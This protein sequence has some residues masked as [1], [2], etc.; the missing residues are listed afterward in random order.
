[1]ST[2]LVAEAVESEVL[3]AGQR[4]LPELAEEANLEYRR[5]VDAGQTMLEAAVHAGRALLAIRDRI[6]DGDWLEWVAEH[7]DGS[8]TTAR[9]CMR[10]AHHAQTLEQEAVTGVFEADVRLQGLSYPFSR[11]DRYNSSETRD[12]ARALAD[13]GLSARTIATM[14]GV[15]HKSVRRWCDPDY[16]QRERERAS[17]Y[18]VRVAAE[19]RAAKAAEK[20]KALE[21]AVKK[22][23]AARA[24]AY[25]AA[26][27]FQD[28]IAKAQREAVGRDER[29]H[30]SEA[31]SHYHKMRDE[32][33]RAFGVS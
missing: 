29:E 5:F 19:K 18:T 33:V 9:R 6:A 1:M 28:V 15:T 22:A 4:T 13:T 16:D 23:G 14:L 8:A 27:R 26:E 11:A 12:E 31:T 17:R 2:T 24:E 7:F 20:Q 25:A 21:R 10:F 30:W 3:E 32:I